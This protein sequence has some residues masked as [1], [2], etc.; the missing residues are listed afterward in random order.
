MNTITRLL[1]PLLICFALNSVQGQDKVI[2]SSKQAKIDYKIEVLE[3]KKLQVENSEKNALKLRVTKINESLDNNE[4]TA[5]QA[6]QLKKQAAEKAALNIQDRLAIID[7]KI[8]LLKRNGYDITNTDQNIALSIGSNGLYVDLT[9]KKK[10]IPKYEI[11]TGNK[12]LFAIGFN[13]TIIDG[14]SLDD[15]PYEL[16][17]SGF[18]EL[19]WVWQTRL[20]KNS[21][22]LRLNYGFSFQWNK[23]NVKG[24]LYFVQDGAETTLQ[25]FPVGLKKSQFRVT[26][27]VFPVHLEIGGWNKK[28]YGNRV[29]YFNHDKFKLGIGGYGGFRIGTQQKLKFKEDGDRVKDKIRRNYNTSNFVY[30]LSAYV[31]IGDISLYAKYDLNPLFKDQDVDQNN[32]SV[33]VRFDI[34]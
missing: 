19:G 9:P 15:S 20:L 4:I 33:G 11:R 7:S 24:D 29:R 8:E 27:L 16:A 14:Q 32:I 5:A 28:D 2:D 13:N 17:G 23:L 34:D 25:E 3:Q 1:V 12:L 18:V 10:E 31:G 22:L 26:N 30:G 6:E 21:N